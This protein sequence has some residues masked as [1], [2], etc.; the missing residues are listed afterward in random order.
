[1]EKLE[2]KNLLLEIAE[3]R[4]EIIYKDNK[5]LA[6]LSW[7]RSWEKNPREADKKD[8]NK[9]KSQ[10]EELGVYKP[11]VVYL[12]KDNATI[13]GGNQRFKILNELRKEYEA[14]GNDKYSYVWVSV[15]NAE[16]DVDKLKYALSDNFSAG[17]YTREKLKEV[18]KLDQASLFSQ[19]DLDFGERQEI[20]EFI[21]SMSKT[22]EQLKSENLSKQLK[23][24]GI[25]EE[26]ISDVIC[27]SNYGKVE[28]NYDQKNIIGTGA[29]EFKDRKIF[30]MK[31]VFGEENE[32][33][34]KE[35]LE[36]YKDAAKL[37]KE[38]NG[39]LYQRLISK[40]SKGTG[41]VLIKTLYLLQNLP[42]KEF[43]SKLKEKAEKEEEEKK[44]EINKYIED[45][46]DVFS[47]GILLNSQITKN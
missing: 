40:Y 4:K 6:K 33:I 1:M 7:L 47:G 9:L 20:E 32:P 12:E 11:L 3:E 30:V 24:A 26:V 39:D 38:E 13:L 35:L 2:Q 19:Y 34:Y 21:D 43:I 14:K 16:N 31:L 8:L 44:E 27:M 28:N 42:G 22:E 23:N 45:N 29:I 10:I 5:T 41:D 15:V 25:D 17:H 36:I 46:E 37:F 18:I